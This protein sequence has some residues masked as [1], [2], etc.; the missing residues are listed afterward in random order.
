M[1]LPVICIFTPRI[2]A[3]RTNPKSNPLGRKS[4]AVAAQGSRYSLLFPGVFQARLDCVEL[5]ADKN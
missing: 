4:L 1:I 2:A 3:T 5:S